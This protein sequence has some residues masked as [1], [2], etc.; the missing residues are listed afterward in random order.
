[1]GLLF[2]VLFD[3]GGESRGR[4]YATRRKHGRDKSR[5]YKNLQK[6]AVFGFWVLSNEFLT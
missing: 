1:M 6:F 2:L 4:I 3:A 5:P